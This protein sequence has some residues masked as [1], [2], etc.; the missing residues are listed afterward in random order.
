M[1]LNQYPYL[2]CSLLSTTMPLE[3]VVEQQVNKADDE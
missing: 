2:D 1:Y 3:L